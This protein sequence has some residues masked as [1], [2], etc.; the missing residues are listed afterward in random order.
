MK[1]DF[2]IS[3][4]VTAVA[5][6]MAGC[7]S[8]Q[9]RPYNTGPY[10]SRQGGYDSRQA[11]YGQGVVDRIEVVKKGDGNNIAGTV[12]GGI[13]GGLIGHQIGSGRGNTAATIAGAAGGAMAGNEIQKRRGN[14]ETFRVTVRM[15]N[16]AN[17]VVTQDD[18][19]D[20][21]TGDRVRVEGGR[22]SR[23]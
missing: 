8:D 10:D 22:L 20:L 9:S 7:A 23:L 19:S 4:A 3:T 5:I 16:G 14:N 18:I 11:S 15:D 6:V 17:E 2:T 12:I 13:A 1:I 21:R